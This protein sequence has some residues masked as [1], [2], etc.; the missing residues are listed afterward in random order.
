MGLDRLS[1]PEDASDE[2]LLV[3]D[4]LGERGLDDVGPVKRVHAVGPNDRLL[5]LDSLGPARCHLEEAVDTGGRTQ[6]G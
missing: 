5:L 6:S 3:E 4:V 1:L 2:E